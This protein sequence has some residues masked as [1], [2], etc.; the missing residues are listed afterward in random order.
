[1]ETIEENA[2]EIIKIVGGKIL[3]LLMFKNER[4]NIKRTLR[5]FEPIVDRWLIL[6]TGST[7]ATDNK[8]KAI[9]RKQNKIFDIV[10]TP[11]IC[12]SFNRNLLL[13]G[14]KQLDKIYSW[15]IMV[16]AGDECKN[17]DSLRQTLLTDN[18]FNM[19]YIPIETDG[20]VKYCQ[21][22]LLSNPTDLKYRY[23]LHET[24]R[25]ISSTKINNNLKNSE[26]P[27]TIIHNYSDDKVNNRDRSKDGERMLAE[28]GNPSFDKYDRKNRLENV[29]HH[30]IRY[31]NLEEARKHFD[32]LVKEYYEFDETSA[33]SE[34]DRINKIISNNIV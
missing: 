23:Q 7:D 21:P 28:M 24:I 4:K 16:D 22:R 13:D 14:A 15:T 12:Y 10:K 26:N 32:L 3:G 17:I 6:D 25:P 2:D 1:M 18:D 11:W 34:W 31:G 27:F 30:Y 9:L 29:V 20:S 33:N 8:I 5:A 19:C